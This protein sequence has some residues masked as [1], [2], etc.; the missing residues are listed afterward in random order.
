MIRHETST[1]NP[2]DKPPAGTTYYQNA[3]KVDDPHLLDRR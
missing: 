2:L 3:N 1:L